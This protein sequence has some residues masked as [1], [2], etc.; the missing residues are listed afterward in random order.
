MFLGRMKKNLLGRGGIKMRTSVFLI[1]CIAVFS[2]SLQVIG[3]TPSIPFGS[4]DSYAYGYMA[5]GASDATALAWYND[6]KGKFVQSCGANGS[7][8]VNTN[9]GSSGFSEGQGYGMLLAAYH[10]DKTLFDNLWKLYKARSNANGLMHWEV[11]CGG[12]N[13]SNAATDGDLD[14]AMALLIAE[15]QW[16][17]A[18]SPYDY[19]AEATTLI[20][21]IYNHETN[22]AGSNHANQTCGGLAVLRPGD[23]FQNNVTCTCI[24]LSY[25]APAYYR[26]F[27]QHVPSQASEWQRLATDSYTLINL[28]KHNSSHLVSAWTRSDGTVPAPNSAECSYSATGGAGPDAYQYDATR[29]PWRIATDY[30][31]WGT[32]A[33][34]TW[35]NQVGTWADNIGAANIVDGYNHNGTSYSSYKNSAFTGAFALAQMAVNQT[36]TNNWYS[37]WSTKSSKSGGTNPN[38]LDDDPYYQNSLATMYMFLA[39]GNFWN[40]YSGECRQ[41]NLGPDLSTCAGGVSFPVS[42]ASNT[43][44]ATG[45]TYT[46]YRNGTVIPSQTGPNCTGCATVAGTYIVVRDSSGGCS[47]RDTMVISN[48]LATPVFPAGLNICS[49][50]SY[51]LTPTNAAAFP[52]GTKWQWA[53]SDD[54]GTTYDNLVGDTL[55]ILAN[56]RTA[57]HYRLTATIGACTSS[58][59]VALTSSLPTPVDRCLDVPGGSASLAIINPGLNGSNYNWYTT[60]SGATIAPGGTGTTT[61]SPTVSTTTTFY[62]QDMSAVNGNVGPTTALGAGTDWG[63][64]AN[65]HLNFTANSNFTLNSLQIPFGPIHANTATATIT[66]EILD[67]TG[68]PFS[69]VRTYT[70]NPRNVTTGMSNSLITFDFTGMT[71][72][73]AW[74]PAL[75]MRLSGKSESLNGAILW[76]AGPASYPYTSA[77]GI[78]SIT[79]QSGG[80]G[81]PNQYNYFYNW[82]ISTGT[83]CDRLPVIAKVG[84]CTLSPVELIGF[85]GALQDGSAIL[86]WQTATETNNDYFQIERSLDGVS[87]EAIG[88]VNGQGTVVG[89]TPYTFADET[90]PFGTVYYRLAQYDYDATVSYSNV[91][92][93]TNE[94]PINVSVTPNPFGQAA[95]LFILAGQET[96]VNVIV[97]D[98]SGRALYQKT[99]PTNEI[100]LIGETLPPGVYLVQ[101]QSSQG[102]KTVKV[103]KQ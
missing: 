89:I 24:N 83:S 9:G 27:A 25:F 52:T 28:N 8:I 82:N 19:G 54:G 44:T 46:W 36:R 71:I 73:S 70:S 63:V 50:A 69:P 66:V 7:L 87:F 76:S 23:A 40:P 91:V 78:V 14:A 20:T 94:A 17:S 68:A 75:R 56:V 22:L 97:S 32:P 45:V 33:A 42:L 81:G 43:P 65:L 98:L 55:A 21:N 59:T 90:T 48:T 41:P 31:W 53:S 16:P 60:P 10:G 39:T 2:S 49:P 101:V 57:G 95:D 77:G 3:Q 29:T 62:V 96:K 35:L 72:Q 80:N 92:Q 85:S 11:T 103:I 13:Q 6:W 79:G 93:L 51:N 88:T 5:T 47:K 74:G 67:G 64:N 15:K 18:T 84:D 30:L 37:H 99:V 34:A 86:S 38:R 26:A 12:V 4:N 1:F 58:G 102:L 61:L 100:T